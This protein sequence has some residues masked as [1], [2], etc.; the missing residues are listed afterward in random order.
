MNFIEF[1]RFRLGHTDGMMDTEFWS[2]HGVY[3]NHKEDYY[4]DPRTWTGTF[5]KGTKISGYRCVD[6][7]TNRM[8]PDEHEAICECKKANCNWSREMPVCSSH[9]TLHPGYNWIMTT[10]PEYGAFCVSTIMGGVGIVTNG[11]CSINMATEPNPFYYDTQS[12]WTPAFLEWY[13][14]FNVYDG[15]TALDQTE[16]HTFS[17]P[18]N[19]GFK[20]VSRSQALAMEE[21][22][23][24]HLPATYVFFENPQKWNHRQ[25]RERAFLCRI[26][27]PDDTVS[28]GRFV[29]GKC[30][31]NT[32]NI[33]VLILDPTKCEK[34]ETWSECSGKSGVNCGPGTQCKANG[35]CRACL[36]TCETGLL[37]QTGYRYEEN[38]NW[39]CTK[40]AYSDFES[41]IG[42][43][44]EYPLRKSL[45]DDGVIM[46]CTGGAK[47][48]FWHTDYLT[49]E[50]YYSPAPG[51]ICTFSC[52][53][54]LY[55]WSK[56]AER[57]DSV[58]CG[59]RGVLDF[60]YELVT[61]EYRCRP[62]HCIFPSF[63]MGWRKYDEP[64]KNSVQ[65]GLTCSGPKAE[66]ND[67]H[68]MILPGDN[69]EF[70]CRSK[71]GKPYRIQTNS[72]NK[73]ARFLGPIE[74]L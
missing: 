41:E 60:A 63:G 18:C 74:R 6:P 7:N 66:N 10:D 4:A 40:Q 39:Y 1:S 64:D 8:Y 31:D 24:V 16:F 32:D 12:M 68:V 61:N 47:V 57:Y 15:V 13:R 49:G 58:E 25:E 9:G 55:S 19:D 44:V 23:A 48:G 54:S 59:K 30:S 20:W 42:L 72:E 22:T 27:F 71:N 17:S 29:K 38:E 35:K 69:C 2:S 52:S 3:Y 33:E 28:Y 50:E 70:V 53:E 46:K 65:M 36:G 34:V 56:I 14:P 21:R 67:N 73:D 51:E 11:K 5:P 26:S 45:T 37:E 62:N 43:F